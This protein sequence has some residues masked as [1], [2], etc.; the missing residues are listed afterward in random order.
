MGSYAPRVGAGKGVTHT[1]IVYLLYIVV[2]APCTLPYLDPR[3]VR[4]FAS[5]TKNRAG[6]PS[7]SGDEG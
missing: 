2:V 4:V 5:L 7:R 3:R 1:A 6:P